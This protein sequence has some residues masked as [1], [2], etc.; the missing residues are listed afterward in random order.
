MKICTLILYSKHSA[1]THTLT[2]LHAHTHTQSLKLFVNDKEGLSL[3]PDKLWYDHTLQDFLT[4]YPI[5][6]P[7]HMFSVDLYCK[8]REANRLHRHAHYLDKHANLVCQHVPNRLKPPLS[9]LNARLCEMNGDVTFNYTTIDTSTMNITSDDIPN[10]FYP[11]NMYEVPAWKTLDGMSGYSLGSEV[12]MTRISGEFRQEMD[13]VIKKATQ[14]VQDHELEELSFHSL[15]NGYV[16][17]SG[18]QGR[19]FILDIQLQNSRR[20]GIN[21]RVHLVRPHLPS[22]VAMGDTSPSVLTRQV[23]FIV[24]LSHVTERFTEFL[25]TYEG[26]CLIP[27]ENCNLVLSVYGDQ[28]YKNVQTRVQEYA[29]QHPGFH[30]NILKGSGLFTRARALNLGLSHLKDADLAFLCDVDMTIKPGFLN[31]CRQNTLR[32]SRVYYPTF[33][34][35]YDMDYVYKFKKKPLTFPIARE[36]GHWASYSYGMVCIY[37]SDYD[38][39]G[40]FNTAIEGW[41]EEDVDLFRKVINHRLDVM[42]TADHGLFHRY[43]DKICSAKL[44]PTQF[45]H[46]I[47]SREEDIADRMQL[48]E[49]VFYLEDKLNIRKRKLWS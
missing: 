36:H 4:L 43:H 18:L 11:K 2:F 19:E 25:K 37:K 20:E 40:G 49:Y 8:H 16:R 27:Q 17:Y 42:R 7:A 10:R 38:A 22:V 14:Y 26:L 47:S 13:Y 12:P 21:R 30:Y 5:R 48:A 3:H 44:N 23:N 29:K 33:F 1:H 9:E 24:P 34:K 15:R 45:K 39:I 35:Y 41:G 28:E 46:C 31:R 32:N 6:S